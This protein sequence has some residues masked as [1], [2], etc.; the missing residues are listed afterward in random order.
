MANVIGCEVYNLLI[1]CI[2]RNRKLLDEP[3]RASVDT[4]R[5]LWMN[6]RPSL[7]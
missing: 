3:I 5:T 1:F 7:D 2:V 4:I 6:I